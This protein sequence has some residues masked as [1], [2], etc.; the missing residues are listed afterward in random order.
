[1]KFGYVPSPEGAVKLSFKDYV[2]VSTV[3][4][5]APVNFGHYSKVSDW[6]MLGND[7]VG[8]CVMAGA[9]HR[10]MLWNAANGKTVNFSSQSVLSDYSVITGYSPDDPDSDQGTDPATAAQYE[11]TTGLLDA[12]GNRH[13]IGAYLKLQTGNMDEL[14]T[15]SYLFG[16]VGMAITVTDVAQH[17]FANR[18]AWTAAKNAN[19]EGGHYVPVVGRADGYMLAVTWGAV[20]PFDQGFFEQNNVELIAYVSTE[21]L[22]AGKSP[23][24]LDQ[25]LLL[26]DLQT[27]SKE[28]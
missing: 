14:V 24:G 10:V 3:L 9:A 16:A 27:I 5:K 26:A 12:D 11:Q 1:M 19:I 17:Q 25:A 23:E 2:D 13:K 18:E 28:K 7:T 22:T 21:Y 15:A 6:G 20:Q 8:D 4:P